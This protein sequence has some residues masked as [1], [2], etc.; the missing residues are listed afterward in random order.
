[1]INRINKFNKTLFRKKIADDAGAYY[2]P[3]CQK[4]DKTPDELITAKQ[5]TLQLLLNKVADW[6][7]IDEEIKPIALVV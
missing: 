1:M 6:C 3:N 2:G 7:K 5:R 4:P